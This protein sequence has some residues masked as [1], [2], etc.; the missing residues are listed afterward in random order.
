MQGIHKNLFVTKVI[1]KFYLPAFTVTTVLVDISMNLTFVKKSIVF[2]K[3][4]CL[5][6]ALL[7]TF[8]TEQ[9]EPNLVHY[10][11]NLYI[12]RLVLTKKNE[13]LVL[14]ILKTK[15]YKLSKLN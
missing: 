11:L 1:Y 12:L 15:K 5:Y 14:F 9:V 10:L 13:R 8:I 2:K 7:I 3:I 6:L 4:L